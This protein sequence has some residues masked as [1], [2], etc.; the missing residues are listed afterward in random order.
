MNECDKHALVA[1]LCCGCSPLRLFSSSVPPC[2]LAVALFIL[3]AFRCLWSLPTLSRS[4]NAF[5]Q[6]DHR[7]ALL[8]LHPCPRP[9]WFSQPVRFPTFGHVHQELSPSVK[10]FFRQGADREAHSAHRSCVISCSPCTDD[11]RQCPMHASSSSVTNRPLTETP[12]VKSPGHSTHPH[13]GRGE[14]LFSQK[15]CRRPAAEK[16][17]FLVCLCG[18]Q[19]D[20]HE[21]TQLAFW[22]CDKRKNKSHSWPSRDSKTPFSAKKLICRKIKKMKKLNECQPEVPRTANNA[23][24]GVPTNLRIVVL[25]RAPLQGLQNSLSSNF[26]LPPSHTTTPHHEAFHSRRSFFPN[27]MVQ[28]QWI[29]M[30]AGHGSAM[31]R[32]ERPAPCVAPSREDDGG[33]GAGDG[34]PPQ[35]TTRGPVV[36]GPREVE[37]PVTNA[38]LRGQ[39]EPSRGAAGTS[40]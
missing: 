32:R 15:P 30:M 37:G 14:A 38:V 1:L 28:T 19:I 40:R 23:A 18:A 3:F 29:A 16:G 36:E 27:F 39:I 17:V 4:K 9:C 6:Q 7:S 20:Q 25:S 8:L 12:A 11:R 21:H 31:R 24:R 26:S 2:F 22:R 35:C 33:H 10:C 13:P 5:F 34:P